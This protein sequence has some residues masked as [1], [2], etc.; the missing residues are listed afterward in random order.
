MIPNK[1]KYKITNGVRSL[2]LKLALFS[3]PFIGIISL[4]FHDDPFK[5]LRKY[6]TYDSAITLNESSVGWSIYKNNRD[7]IH[8]NS[9][10][11]GNSCTMAFRCSEWEKYLDGGR[12][13]RLFGN[14]ETIKAVYEKLKALDSQNA[15]I[16]N[17]LI[18]LDK[19]S[20]SEYL[21]RQGVY[22]VLPHD[23]SGET[24][25]SEQL[26]Y[27]QTFVSPDFLFPY[28]FSYKILNIVPESGAFNQYGRI[29]N[30]K[31]NDSF[32]PREKWIAQEGKRYWE[33]RKND[34]SVQEGKEIEQPP[35]IK[36]RQRNILEDIDE[37]FMKH[38][39]SF[40][41][42]ISPNYKECKLNRDDLATLQDIFG[43][44]NVF[45]FSGMNEYSKNKY[46]YYERNHYRP[47]LGQKLLKVVY[48][49]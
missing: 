3:L 23:I 46:F 15:Q 31:N 29:R 32:N 39:T 36:L 45:D 9:F 5:V 19:Q 6:N 21:L 30:P 43:D 33:K 24:W 8:F 28:I 4:Y 12:A 47:I 11:L 14:A 25:F 16:D 13:V 40:K 18:I 48:K 1:Q 7:S 41:I 37:I 20:L 38:N 22:Y 49:N 2:M 27:I 42:I 10:I 17:V 26:S 44:N 34:F 35:V